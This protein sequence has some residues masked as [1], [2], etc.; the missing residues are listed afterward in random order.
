MNVRLIVENDFS[1][2]RGRFFPARDP[3]SRHLTTVDPSP[4]L[5]VRFS[6]TLTF[7]TIFYSW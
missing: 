4:L 2:P 6:K 3:L 7:L 5:S 1:F